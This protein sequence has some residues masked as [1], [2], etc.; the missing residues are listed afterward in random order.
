MQETLTIIL[1]LQMGEL[2]LQKVR[3]ELIVLSPDPPSFLSP[4]VL[5][6]QQDAL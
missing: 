2:R 5:C 6:R 1:I 4:A 3:R